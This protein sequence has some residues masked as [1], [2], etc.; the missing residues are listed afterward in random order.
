MSKPEISIS[1]RERGKGM[2]NFEVHQSI[3][4]SG[5]ITIVRGIDAENA[6]DVVRAIAAG[7]IEAIEITA[8]TPGSIEIIRQIA[9]E[10]GDEVAIGAGTVLDPETA[11]AVQLAG[12]EFVVTPT[13]NTDVIKTCNRYNTPMAAGVMTAAEALTATEAGADFCKLFPA[14]VTGPEQVSGINGPLLQIPLVP[15]GGVSL[16]N[17]QEFFDAGAIALGVGSAI[18]DNE[19]IE[20]E[21][22]DVLTQ[23]SCDFVKL[24][25]EYR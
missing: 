22:F 1:T 16:N 18:V 24:A 8:D 20:A 11:R 14:S 5:I 9:A 6:I 10:V 7:G 17:A 3:L 12:A 15:T 25:E 2:N 4:N 21:Q 19:A 13:V 23:T